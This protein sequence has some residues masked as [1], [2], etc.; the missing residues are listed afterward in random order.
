M[1]VSW[2]QLAAVPESSLK[3]KILKALDITPEPQGRSMVFHDPP[4]YV[5][6]SP[7]RDSYIVIERL[8]CRFDSTCFLKTSKEVLRSIRWPKG[9]PV[10]DSLRAFL[11]FHDTHT[12][13]TQ[14]T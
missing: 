11:Q 1:T 3:D 13:S 9:T 12:L 6:V 2:R 4:V 8:D 5:S 14:D 10:G 7:G